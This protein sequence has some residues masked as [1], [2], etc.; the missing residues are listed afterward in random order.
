MLRALA[1]GVIPIA[2]EGISSEL[3]ACELLIGDWTS[4]RVAPLVEFAADAE[5]LLSAGGSDQADDHSEAREW[6]ASPVDRDVREHLV[7]DLV[8]FARAPLSANMLET[9]M[10]VKFSEGMEWDHVRQFKR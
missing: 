4:L 2:V 9:P 6:L 10:P 5:S 7:L 3:D 1:D 8:P